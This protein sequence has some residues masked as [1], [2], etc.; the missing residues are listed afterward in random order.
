M[1]K[2]VKGNNSKFIHFVNTHN[3]RKWRPV[4]EKVLQTTKIRQLEQELIKHTRLQLG[5]ETIFQT[6]GDTIL[7]FYAFSFTRTKQDFSALFQNNP[8]DFLG[9]NLT[10]E[11]IISILL[12]LSL[13]SLIKSHYQG[14]VE[15]YGSNYKLFGKSMVVLTIMCGIIVKVMSCVMYFAPVLGLFNLLRHYQ[16]IFVLF[17]VLPRTID[18]HTLKDS[19]YW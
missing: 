17:F 1:W 19:F 8:V 18:I 16:G 3:G 10:P 14:L 9:L 13:I 15:G 7:L 11:V 4:F 12:I 5:L 6:I 2:E